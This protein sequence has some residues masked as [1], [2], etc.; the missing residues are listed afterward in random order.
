MDYATYLQSD[1]W[2]T[3]A[4]EAKRRARY[5]CALCTSSRSLEVHHRT[6]VRL[7]REAESDL[8][9]L[10]RRCHRRH[11]GTYEECVELHAFLPLLPDA[12]DMN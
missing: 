5:E 2:K 11:H 3:R 9:V 7:G 4:A 12:S 8:I 1:V 6:Y 10:C